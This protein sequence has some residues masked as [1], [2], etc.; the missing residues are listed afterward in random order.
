MQQNIWQIL[1]RNG[2]DV[3]ENY[4]YPYF[5]A[6]DFEAL[7]SALKPGEKKQTEQTTYTS[8]H[9]PMSVSVSSNV[10]GFDK[11][12]CFVSEN[13]D[14]PQDLV[15]PMMTY[16]KEMSDHA[17]ELLQREFCDI[18]QEISKLEADPVLE[19]PPQKL[20]K[21]LDDYLHELP[22]VG[23]NS[24]VYDINLIKTAFFQNLVVTDPD[25]DVAESNECLDKEEEEQ[26]ENKNELDPP[27]NHKQTGIKFIIKNNNEYK[28]IAT[29][30]LKFLDIKN[31]IAPGFSYEKYLAAFEIEQKKGF[32]P[33]E[34]ITSLDTLKET[35]LPP[36]E[37]FY[38]SLKG[39]C[40]SQEEYAYCQKVWEEEK[41]TSLKDFLIW[42][43]NLDVAPFL[44][45]LTKQQK[46][47]S[48]LGL[49]LLK[50]G[51]GIPGLTLKYLFKTLDPRVYFSL[52]DDRNSDLHKLLREEMVG[53]P[54]LIFHRYHEKDKTHIRGG[55]DLVQSII[56]FDANALYLWALS[57]PMPTEQPTR[58]RRHPPNTDNINKKD[59]QAEK[60]DK[61]GQKAR[62]WLEWEA[63][64]KK[65][66]IQHKFNGKERSLGNRH[67]RVDGYCSSQRL[68]FQFHGCAFHGHNCALTKGLTHHP[69]KKDVTQQELYNKTKEI[70]LYLTQDLEISLVEMWECEW[71]RLKTSRDNIRNFVLSNFP[72]YVSPFPNPDKIDV[73]LIIRFVKEKKFF[74]LVQCDI[75]VPPHLENYFEELQPIFK[76]T[77]ISRNDIGDFMKIY[78][79]QNKIL[80]QPRRTLV[81]S[82]W[83]KGIML[84]T[85]LLE[86][87]LNH[88]LVVTDIQQIIEYKPVAC[89][90]NF[91]N[92][93]S[94]ARRDGDQHPN[95][96]ILA[97][98]FKLLGN[99]AYG[100]T[101]TNLAKHNNIHYVTP[102]EANK[103]IKKTSV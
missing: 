88:G 64:N 95:Q 83:A 43:N 103:L 51:V 48:D 14:R 102:Q 101:L 28:C 76:N 93:V 91:A 15:N 78:A 20:K 84:I 5:A 82:Y 12:V 70:S 58:R 67:I 30:R 36:I 7:L 40:I 55:E 27:Q 21:L 18:Y 63:H 92:K 25:Y 68:A 79:E 45:A 4:V 62:E 53:G 75:K 71:E 94:N 31:Y 99:S 9:A 44:Q 89:F 1:K 47:Y 61:Y 85:P 41:M 52:I 98:T 87:Y 80:S 60:I 6:Y 100:K 33:Y 77:K 69:Y 74:G 37:A 26:E 39:K 66:H 2:F 49:D 3:P 90:Q 23:F 96:A 38:S 65:I 56:G 97:D 16:L 34:Y 59:F 11:E 8:K 73:P 29:R 35:K 10:P 50:D 22:V 46:F 81:G 13:T 24:S 19:F 86:W 32:F 72:P 42:Y 54:S 57:Q 17:F